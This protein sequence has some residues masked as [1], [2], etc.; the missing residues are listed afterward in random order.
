MTNMDMPVGSATI[1]VSTK[2]APGSAVQIYD[3]AGFRPG[4]DYALVIPPEGSFVMDVKTTQ[5]YPFETQTL[6]GGCPEWIT[7][8][9]VTDGGK[10]PRLRVKGTAPN[11]V[12]GGVTFTVNGTADGMTYTFPSEGVPMALSVRDAGGEAVFEPSDDAPVGLGFMNRRRLIMRA[13]LCEYTAGGIPIPDGIE[14]EFMMADAAGG[15]IGFYDRA[16]RKAVLYTAP[17]TEA[18]GTLEDV[19]LIFLGNIKV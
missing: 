6:G 1:T 10:E 2:D 5:V 11:G 8:E 7:L 9:D 17:G 14:P 18:S 12:E 3:R 4:M 13:D 19:T 15:I 16:N